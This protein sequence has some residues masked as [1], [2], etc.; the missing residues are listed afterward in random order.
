MPKVS[1][2]VPVYNVEKYLSK[3]LDS[4]VNQTLKDIE[5]IIVNDGSPDHSQDI[6]DKYA[7][8]YSKKIR[9]F[10]KDNGGQASARNLGLTKA[11]GEY[12]LFVDS[13]DYIELDTCNEL[14][15]N[16]KKLNSDIVLFDYYIIY[17]KEHNKLMSVIEKVND[18][19]N[20]NKKEFFL[21]TPSPVNKL[22]RRE[23]LLKHNFRFPEGII[24][25]DYAEIPTLVLYD[26]KISY[27]KKPF[28]FYIQSEE[29]TTRTPKYKQKFEDIFIAS[30]YLYERLKD[31]K[32][33]EE[34]LEYRFIGYLLYE[35]SLNFYKYRR[36]DNIK[37]ISA[38]INKHYPKWRHNKYYKQK[39]FKY[40][41][42]C[43]LFYLKQIWLIDLVRKFK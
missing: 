17:S 10:Q 36:I 7:K 18:V 40:K 5:I 4:L 33:L 30:D 38:W 19:D 22:F 31:D 26:P 28:Y 8:R 32:D 41:V 2:I 21:S 23:F 37:R 13:D 42:L 9:A 16:A 25:E 27:V 35:G 15:N 29:S 34:E 1:I 43:N 6:I 24:Y 11:T 3:C 14:Y 12:I 39:D 20:I